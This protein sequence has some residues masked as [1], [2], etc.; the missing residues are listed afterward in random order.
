MAL[1]V[2]LYRQSQAFIMRLIFNRFFSNNSFSSASPM[3]LN[4]ETTGK[5]SIAIDRITTL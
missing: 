2:F 1:T 5:M 3:T 4:H